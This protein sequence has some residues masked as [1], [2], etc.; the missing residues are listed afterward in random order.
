MLIVMIGA[1]WKDG[2][3]FHSKQHMVRIAICMSLIV[4][5]PFLISFSL[6]KIYHIEKGSIKEMLSLPFQQ[7]A[8]YVTN[9]GDEVTDE[10]RQVIDR[11][12][13]YD[14]LALNYDPM[15]SDR[16]KNTFKRESTF[17][18]L[19]DYVKVW[20]RQFRRHPFTYINATINQNYRLLYPAAKTS[21][22]YLDTYKNRGD[23]IVLLG[24]EEIEPIKE[25]EYNLKSFYNIMFQLPMLGIFSRV[26]FY[27]LLLVYIL[28][29]SVYKRK[30]SI[31]FV[32]IPVI[33]SNLVIVAAPIVHPRYALPIIYC[34]PL[35]MAYAIYSIRGEGDDAIEDEAD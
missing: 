26:A 24:I 31:C 30:R 2:V 20:F 14:N 29:V 1:L 5:I 3:L 10:E 27:N 23:W 12:L 9:H 7:T 19:L 28:I 15:L 8:R 16:V 11:I 17:E 18:S 13:D 21:A 33:I 22:L 4:F 32:S 25:K 34:M 6:D 35:V